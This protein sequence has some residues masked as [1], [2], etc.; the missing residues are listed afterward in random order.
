MPVYVGTRRALAA[1]ASIPRDLFG[2]PLSQW[3][4]GVVATRKYDADALD[5]TIKQVNARSGHFARDAITSLFLEFSDL[6]VE[7]T[8]K[9]SGSPTSVSACIEY[10]AGRFTR[11]LFSGAT[12]G[13]MPSGGDL[14]SDAILLS[15]PR[16]AMFWIWR[17]KENATGW[18]YNQFLL[19]S[20]TMGDRTQIA[21]SGLTDQSNNGTITNNTSI[22]DIAP[23][24]LAQTKR[25]TLLFV[26]DSKGMGV[27]SD[28]AGS[29]TGDYGEAC[30]VLGSEFAYINCCIGGDRVSRF[31]ASYAR[32]ASR[33]AYCSHA[34][35]NY[36]INDLRNSRTPVQI[37]DDLQY[38]SGRL[39]RPIYQLTVAPATLLTPS[40]D[41]WTTLA[42]Q[43]IEA[44]DTV[45]QTLNT[46]LRTV[47]D[48]FLAV[49]D[50]AS[51]MESAIEAGKWVPGYTSD[52]IHENAVGYAAIRN[53]N[54]IPFAT[55]TRP[56]DE[57]ALSAAQVYYNTMTVKPS[58]SAKTL[59]DTAIGDMQTAGLLALIEIMHIHGLHDQ[60][61]ARLNLKSPHVYTALRRGS[62]TFTAVGGFSSASGGDL[63][64]TYIQSLDGVLATQDS[65]SLF[66]WS[67][68]NLR[69]NLALYGRRQTLG[70]SYINPW[71]S[72]VDS[73]GH[74]VNDG[75]GANAFAP[76]SAAGLFHVSRRSGANYDVY[77]NGVLLGTQTKASASTLPA[78]DIRILGSGDLF[79]TKQAW[80]SGLGAGMT[81]GNVSDLYTILNTLKTGL[82]AL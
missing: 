1:R 55:F 77:R 78:L 18:N 73:V 4:L 24:V 12:V 39:K 76:G 11:V 41:G 75:S 48:P 49:F 51:I 5:T 20:T 80:C 17:F 82:E 35:S 56:D 31:V 9:A 45:R 2:F 79:S 74:G 23:V 52:G 22:L 81:A 42:G 33:A 16:G 7:I 29:L 36:G 70:K 37:Q 71:N 64:T 19:Q 50:T 54:L 63:G 62:V 26:G 6:Y 8:E 68:T 69:E 57:T 53:S 25:P 65:T 60:Q 44:S 27:G 15:I 34:F 28:F 13:S 66:V 46:W 67:N 40:T 10:P 43:T 32:R 14:R 59:I 61:A 21:A 72:T 47:P 58:A 38:M 30:S 3:Y